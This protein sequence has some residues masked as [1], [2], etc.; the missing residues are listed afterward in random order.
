MR[1]PSGRSGKTRGTTTEERSPTTHPTPTNPDHTI[2][3]R[4][5]HLL[6]PARPQQRRLHVPLQQLVRDHVKHRA[7]ERVLARVA[8]QPLHDRVRQR[9]ALRA[10]LRAA[11]RE[12]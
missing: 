10:L 6:R 12:I 5:T 11:L 2:R 1:N 9:L 7:L 4:P 3:N 8:L